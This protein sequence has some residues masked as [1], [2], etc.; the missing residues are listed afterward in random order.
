MWNLC[1]LGVWYYYYTIE[2]QFQNLIHPKPSGVAKLIHFCYTAEQ[3][4]R[5]HA[6]PQKFSV[7][8]IVGSEGRQVNA[9]T[10][11]GNAERV[12]VWGTRFRTHSVFLN[13]RQML[14]W[15][16]S[17]YFG[18]A[19][20]FMLGTLPLSRP[21]R[22][23][24]RERRVQR[25]IRRVSPSPSSIPVAW[26]A[27]GIPAHR[28]SHLPIFQTGQINGVVLVP[29]RPHLYQRRER[30]AVCAPSIAPAGAAR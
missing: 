29:R 7:H 9:R 3:C 28:H 19:P 1:V 21:R 11:V 27:C 5:K 2:L 20:L 6:L 18:R 4:R 23:K 25:W 24:E 12:V 17:N 14:N 16:Q 13:T 22:A 26:S 15:A 30:E 10:Q 8:K